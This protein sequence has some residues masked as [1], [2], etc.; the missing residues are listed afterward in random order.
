MA[1][2]ISR[3]AFLSSSS[4]LSSSCFFPSGLILRREKFA[5]PMP[6]KDHH[7]IPSSAMTDEESMLSTRQ[8][9][10]GFLLV[11]IDCPLVGIQSPVQPTVSLKR[12]H[13][14]FHGA[15]KPI[16]H[17]FIGRKSLQ[18]QCFEPRTLPCFKGWYLT[19]QPIPG[20]LVLATKM[21]AHFAQYVSM[22]LGG[23]P[24]LRELIHKSTNHP[25]GVDGVLLGDLSHQ[26]A[27]A[28]NSHPQTLLSSPGIAHLPSVSGHLQLP[29]LRSSTGQPLALTRTL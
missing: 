14:I 21:A 7:L 15:Q 17:P 2:T 1:L 11:L 12:V 26:V 6:L 13:C 22:S 8:T 29:I 23:K 27:T 5:C 18:A 20:L 4:F 16:H 28:D 19:T 10:F 25:L 3:L 9:P 24:L